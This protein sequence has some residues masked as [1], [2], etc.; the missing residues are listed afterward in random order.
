MFAQGPGYLKDG[1]RP[2][3]TLNHLSR[4][5]TGCFARASQTIRGKMNEARYF[6]SLAPA[7]LV[8]SAGTLV[9]SWII[10]ALFPLHFIICA[11]SGV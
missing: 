8:S 7:L 1:N 10:C 6:Y 9:T 2:L 5:S 4:L 3:H 11:S